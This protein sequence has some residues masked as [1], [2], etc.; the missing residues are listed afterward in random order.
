MSNHEPHDELL[1]AQARRAEINERILALEAERTR[2][3]KRIADLGVVVNRPELPCWQC[4]RP[5]AIDVRHW[6][7]S[8]YDLNAATSVTGMPRGCCRI[9]TFG[10]VVSYIES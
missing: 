1:A 8:S 6:L 7:N 4:D 2:L 5:E 9:G 3:D 10:R